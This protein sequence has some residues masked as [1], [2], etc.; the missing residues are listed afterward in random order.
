MLGSRECRAFEG[1]GVQGSGLKLFSWFLPAQLLGRAPRE[2]PK[3]TQSLK[4]TPKT[5]P[6]EELIQSLSLLVIY[7]LIIHDHF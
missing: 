7:Y 1:F 2:P 6:W 4:G 5:Q 3:G